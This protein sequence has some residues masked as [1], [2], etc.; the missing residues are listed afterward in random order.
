MNR[1][2]SDPREQLRVMFCE[3]MAAKPPEELAQVLAQLP[4]RY[5]EGFLAMIEDHQKRTQK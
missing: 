1:P 3:T 4:A 5:R 2:Q